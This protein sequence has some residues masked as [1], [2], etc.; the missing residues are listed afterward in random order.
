MTGAGRRAVYPRDLSPERGL[1][2]R[3]THCD[4]LPW[5]L[6][7]GLPCASS[8]LRAPSF[9]AIGNA[10]LI[11]DRA[12][13]AV[14]EPPHGTLADYVPF[15]FTPRSPMLLNIKTGWK[16]ITKRPNAD[17]VVMVT[18]IARLAAHGVTTL[19]TDRHAFIRTARWTADHAELAAM[20]D[21]RILRDSDFQNT[22]AYPDKMD[23]YMAEA[24]AHGHVPTE[25]LLGLAC[26]SDAAKKKVEMM[27]QAAG[28]A[29]FV[30]ARPEW[31][32]R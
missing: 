4:N 27:A 31:Y 13:H 1:L 14:R 16:G 6:A 7:N 2:F 24:L 8:P 32:F 10:D 9:V 12:R 20:L 28:V 3:I 11:E 18:S 15:Y 21:W 23:R 19:F 30:E 29:M 22:D 5:L 26:A 17:I 25:A